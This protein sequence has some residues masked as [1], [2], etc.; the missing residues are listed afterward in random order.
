MLLRPLLRLI[1]PGGLA[2]LPSQCHIC[3][4]WPAQPLCERCVA[5]FAQ[6][7]ARC[8]RCALPLTGDARICGACLKNP[9]PLDL[10][11]AAVHYAWPWADRITQF[12]FSA[13]PGLAT[14]LAALLGAAPGVASA[15]GAADLLIPLPLSDRRLAERGYNPAQLLAERIAP[16]RLPPR[17][18]LLLRT[19]HTA[20]QHDLPRAQRLR[21]VRGAYAV[22][23]LLA[24]QLA[25]RRVVLVDD[26]MTTGA[27]LFDAARAVRGAG[28]AHV[29][30]LALART[31]PH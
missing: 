6:P 13:E 5:R 9:P 2:A 31:P 7:V 18:D 10:C 17:L 22:D 24:T 30:A 21:N 4:A 25:G 29:T 19:R 23:P 12:K 16:A 3:H 1:R 27:S 14:P 8:E 15:L 20:P 11:L 28:A 26:V